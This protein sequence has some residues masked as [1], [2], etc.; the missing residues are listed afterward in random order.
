MNT[1][2]RKF[3]GLL[4]VDHRESPGV[5]P[6]QAR[7]HGPAVGAGQLLETP[8]YTCVHCQRIVIMNPLRTRPRVYCQKCD[9]YTCDECEALRVLHPHAAHHSFA[10]VMDLV[11]SGQPMAEVPLILRGAA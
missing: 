2:K 4:I 1:S 3:E 6:E 8:T 5:T 10:E 7:G 9:D 11:Q